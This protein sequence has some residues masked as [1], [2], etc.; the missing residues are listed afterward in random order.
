M[1]LNKT[2]SK[3]L[4]IIVPAIILS[5]MFLFVKSQIFISNQ[6]IF[7]RALAFDL[8]VGIPVLHYI[9][10]GNVVPDF[11]KL[12]K[13]F[14]ICLICSTFLIPNA[15]IE[16]IQIINKWLYPIAKIWIAYKV[17]QK[18][19]IVL[20]DYKVQSL[21]LKGH[22][23][24]IKIIENAFKGKIAEILKMEFN[25]VY[26]L[27][28][29]KRES[30][31]NNNEFGYTT[32]KGTVEMVSAFIFIIAIETIVAHIL[33][34]KLNL[35]LAIICSYGSLYLIILFISI[36]K[37]RTH[38]P[39]IIGKES[40]RLQYGYV[41]NSFVEYTDIDYI[42]LTTKSSK[43]ELMKLS[44][45]KGIEKH[46]VVMHFLN[47]QKITKVFGIKKQYTSIGIYVDN[48]ELFLEQ[49]SNRIN[50][51]PDGNKL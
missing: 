9:L 35:I 10:Q 22:E 42:E 12:L 6:I 1:I 28:A 24:Y 3:H 15:D 20:N 11:R 2:Y 5:G 14:T 31:Y 38:F 46:N 51:V 34:S 8:L 33:L 47:S 44:A 21:K 45:F 17:V 25:V 30:N 39:I 40:L 36:L 48:P 49:V 27:F 23:L 41:N 29:G 13:T 26:F 18:L 7:S 16:I 43:S 50:E 19:L 37:S 4:E 32:I